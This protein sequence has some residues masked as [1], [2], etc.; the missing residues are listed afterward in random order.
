MVL[1]IFFFFHRLD[2]PSTII[3]DSHYFGMNKN[4]ER[5]SVCPI[6]GG[7]T[8]PARKQNT[9]L[10]FMLLHYSLFIDSPCMDRGGG[11]WPFGHLHCSSECYFCLLSGQINESDFPFG[12]YRKAHGLNSLPSDW[13]AQESLI[14]H[15]LY[16]FYLFVFYGWFLF[17]FL[18]L[19][20]IGN[21]V[22]KW[23]AFRPR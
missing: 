9:N 20:F 2:I 15:L 23:L 7:N 6:K 18:H 1:F 13:V 5:L 22:I 11:K 21:T 14:I 17:K 12:Q 19:Y 8:A 10:V 16:F 4:W 3:F